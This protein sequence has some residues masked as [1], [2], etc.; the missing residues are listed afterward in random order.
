MKPRIMAELELLLKRIDDHYKFSDTSDQ[1]IYTGTGGSEWLLI[2]LFKLFFLGPALL[3][4]HLATS[5]FYSTDRER[6]QHELGLCLNLLEPSLA[7]LKT[8]RKTFLCG[9]AGP[10]A[11]GAVT[12]HKLGQDTD[13]LQCIRRLVSMYSENK[14]EFETLPSELLYG[15]A[16][17]LYALLFVSSFIPGSVELSLLEEVGCNNIVYYNYSYENC[18]AYEVE[19]SPWGWMFCSHWLVQIVISRC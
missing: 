7:H 17:Y 16:G 10:L 19:F 6:Y 15:Q 13:S 9:G 8:H 5:V 14:K 2:L 4:L 12:Y 3:H 1:S 11:I 18:H